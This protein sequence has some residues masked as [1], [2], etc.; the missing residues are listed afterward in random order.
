[1]GIG[2]VRDEQTSRRRQ[3]SVVLVTVMTIVV[4][5]AMVMVMPVVSVLV[6]AGC[7]GD[8]AE[9]DEH[10]Q[11]DSGEQT[12]GESPQTADAQQKMFKL[13]ERTTRFS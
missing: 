3:A 4:P 6:T 2:T 1:M 7:H 12:H 8:R 9:K 5:A 13:K 11:H 10:Q